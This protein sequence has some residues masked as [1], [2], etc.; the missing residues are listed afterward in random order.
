ME[1]G[2]GS[3]VPVQASIQD[4][5]TE[6]SELSAHLAS[7]Q[8]GSKRPVLKHHGTA[9]ANLGNGSSGFLLPLAAL[10]PNGSNHHAL[11]GI[12]GYQVNGGQVRNAWPEPLWVSGMG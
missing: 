5:N 3:A 6:S 8:I 7:K 4:P 9:E 1:C 2:R 12:E 10:V 11:D